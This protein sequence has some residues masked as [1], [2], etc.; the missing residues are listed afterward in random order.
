MLERQDQA[1][2]FLTLQRGTMV[3]GGMDVAG[4]A[5]GLAWLSGARAVLRDVVREQDGELEP[6]LQCSQV[7]EELS[8]VANVALGTGM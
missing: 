3:V 6:T 8:H 1:S 5:H 7:A 2:V 4:P